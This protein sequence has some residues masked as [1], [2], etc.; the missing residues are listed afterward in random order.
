M[1]GWRA[2]LAALYDHSL[3]FIDQQSAIP[4]RPRG[5]AMAAPQL[6]RIFCIID[7]TSNHQRALARSVSI[8]AES[9]AAIHAYVAV[10]IPDDVHHEDPD[11]F[12]AAELSRYRL[13]LDN[14]TAPYAADGVQ[15]TTEA[16]PVK[17]WRDALAP[18]AQRAEADLIVRSTFRRS[19]LRRQ[20]LKSADWKLLREARCPVL[21]VKSDRVLALDKVLVA[22]NLRNEDQAHQQLTDSVIAYAQAVSRFTGGELHAVNAYQGSMNFVHPPDLAKRLDID[23]RRAHVG[24][25]SPEAVITQIAEKISAPLVIIGSLSR[26]GVSGMVVGNTAERILDGVDADVLTVVQAP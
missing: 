19:P 23:R 3:I 9:R 26:R 5:N 15:I 14:L 22:V 20:M 1:T 6:Q 7:P 13:W 4:G 8:A 25:G 2:T 24:E 21:L 17:D 18:A 12:H 10:Q 11:E 16:E